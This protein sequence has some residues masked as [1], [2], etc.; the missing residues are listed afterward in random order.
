VPPDFFPPPPALGCL[1][2]AKRSYRSEQWFGLWAPTFFPL[3]RFSD[4]NL[5]IRNR[6]LL[7]LLCYGLGPFLFFPLRSGEP[8]FFK[9]VGPLAVFLLD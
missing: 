9:I 1:P 2:V 4:S 5:R 8:V 6:S 3:V 7:L